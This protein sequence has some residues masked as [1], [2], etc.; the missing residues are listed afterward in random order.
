MFRNTV[1]ASL[2]ALSAA[3]ASA[4]QAQAPDTTGFIVPATGGIVGGG[5]GAA[6]VGGGDNLVILYSGAGAGA[7]PGGALQAQAP[8]LARAR[9]GYGGVSIDYLEPE[10]APPG[11]EAWVVGGGDNAQVVYSDPRR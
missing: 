11:R 1:F 8:R 2:I 6:I 5:G 10:T 3:G 7:G 9:N 4:A